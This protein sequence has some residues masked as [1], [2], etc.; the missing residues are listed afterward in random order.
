MKNTKKILV[1]AL[2]ALLLVAVSVAGT[3]AYLTA[4][5]TPVTNTFAPSN[6]ALELEETKQSD[7]TLLE[8][9]EAWKG[10]FIPG[11]TLT[12]D[13]KVTVTN[14]V[15]CYVYL[16]VTETNWDDNIATYTIDST[17]TQL[18]G[19]TDVWYKEVAAS[20]SATELNVITNQQITVQNVENMNSLYDTDDQGV[21][22]AK[23]VKLVFKAYACQKAPANDPVTAWTDY[24]SS[25]N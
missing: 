8:E 4:T 3:V 19:Y 14:D 23:E 2:A 16:K 18:N 15:D 11:T 25:G 7:G 5:T 20:T 12:K 13:P 6:I 10:Q 17:W 1:V 21:K 22:K 9:N 24:L